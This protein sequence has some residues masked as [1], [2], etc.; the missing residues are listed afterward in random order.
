LQ[1]C[2]LLPPAYGSPVGGSPQRGLANHDKGHG[3]E[4]PKRGGA[5]DAAITPIT[6]VASVRF[7]LVTRSA[8]PYRSDGFSGLLGSH[9]CIPVCIPCLARCSAPTFLPRLCSA[10]ITA[11]QSSYGGSD[12]CAMSER[13]AKWT[14]RLFQA[15]RSPCF[16]YPTFQTI[17]SPTTW[18]PPGAALSR[19]VLPL[20]A[21]GF[22]VAFQL[23]FRAY[24]PQGSG[25]RRSLAGSPRAP[26][27]N[28]FVILR[29]GR[30]PPVAL[31]PASRRRSYSRLQAV[32]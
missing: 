11:H 3:R 18:C 30:S 21:P 10:P 23:S 7:Q 22:P 28:G 32:A 12:S 26:G 13:L 15:H 19:Y 2:R 17:P 8:L 20:S 31:H 25:L 16:T 29:T 24:F 9:Q 14:F 4:Y 5:A 27:R 1:P 6:E